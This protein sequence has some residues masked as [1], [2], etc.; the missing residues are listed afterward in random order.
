M[1]EEEEEEE[2]MMD[3]SGAGKLG[4]RKAAGKWQD[5]STTK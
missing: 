5:R 1:R 4:A 2:E 3:G